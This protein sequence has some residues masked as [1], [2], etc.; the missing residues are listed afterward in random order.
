MGS[1]VTHENS[2]FYHIVESLKS[3]FPRKTSQVSAEPILSSSISVR[4]FINHDNIHNRQKPTIF[5]FQ[6]STAFSLAFCNDSVSLVL[7]IFF[8]SQHHKVPTFLK[9]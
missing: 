6:Y 4:V 5:N 3:C 8:L 7:F 9:C 2:S 1:V